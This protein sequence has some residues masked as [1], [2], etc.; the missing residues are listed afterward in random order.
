MRIHDFIGI[1]CLIASFV[2]HYGFGSKLG[3]TGCKVCGYT[4]SVPAEV[5]QKL[6]SNARYRRKRQADEEDFDFEP[7]PD[8][9][10]DSNETR[11]LDDESYDEDD[12]RIVNGYVVKERP[13]L[14][15]IMVHGGSC[16]GAVLNDRFILTAAHC[17]CRNMPPI[18]CTVSI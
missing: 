14:V 2:T 11:S 18:K 16:G 12:L 8:M 15:F 4:N 9:G 17:F 1:L 10:S 5:E 6:N 13:W 7:P 3:K